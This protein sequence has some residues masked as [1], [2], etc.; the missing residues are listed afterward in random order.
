MKIRHGILS[1]LLVG[2]MVPS[3]PLFAQ[4]DMMAQLRQQMNN[5][6]EAI[7][8]GLTQKGCTP[9]EAF[10]IRAIHGAILA[11]L[12]LLGFGIY[13]GRR[14][15]G[16]PPTPG[17]PQPT[18]PASVLRMPEATPEM[19]GQ[20]IPKIHTTARKE[21]GLE[22]RFQTALNNPR[23]YR[24]ALA[25]LEQGIVLDAAMAQQLTSL[26]QRLSVSDAKKFKD[27]LYRLWW[28]KKINYAGN[29]E[30]ALDNFFSYGQ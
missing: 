1:L 6:A 29:A 27:G 4:G 24:E 8:C 14:G 11:L 12:A 20:Y 13:R 15:S 18:M 22:E 10:R 25:A 30:K 28:N 19:M 23:S 7:K 9:Q 21:T 2:M 5:Y 16:V 3:A 17:T 26:E